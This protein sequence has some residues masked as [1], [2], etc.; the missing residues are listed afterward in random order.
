MLL[1]LK[2]QN[3]ALIDELFVEFHRGFNIITGETG[4]GKSILLGALGLI[5]GKRAETSVLSNSDEKCVVEAEFDIS[6]YNLKPLFLEN[7]IDFD[8][9]AVFRREIL[10]SGKSRA[11]I[12]DTPVNLNTLQDVAL[13]LVDIHSQHQNLLL[14][15]QQYILN[16]VDSY[17][18]N[19]ALLKE[20]Q[21]VYASFRE[22]EKEYRLRLEAYNAIRGELDLFSFQYNELN[23]A[24]LIAGEQEML[25]EELARLENAGDIKLA[26]HEAEGALTDDEH[27]VIGKLKLIS[28]KLDRIKHVFAKA[29]GISERLSGALIELKDIEA[30]IAGSFEKLEF[31]PER[32]QIIK[33]R[34]D[35]INS[36]LQKYRKA[37]IDGLLE[38]QEGLS[39][40]LSLA[41]DGGEEIKQLKGNLDK[42][43]GALSQKSRDLTQKRMLLF[44]E[45]ENSLT[46]MLKEMGMQHALVEFRHT[47]REISA[48][49]A[50]DIALHFT[51]NKN[52]PLQEVSKI[53]SGGELSRLMLAVKALVSGSKKMPT[54][55]LDEIDT[56]VS[57]DIADKVGNIIKQMCKESQ[58]INITHLPQVASKGEAHFLVYKDHDHKATRTLIKKL[59]NAERVHEIAKML[60]GEQLSGAAV[61]NARILL[62]M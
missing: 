54:L 38:M 31:D 34:L 61:E 27:G 46:I 1:S 40:K 4:A 57:G 24:K 8:N 22:Q 14:N 37:N 17:G 32:H 21:Q 42:L 56:G 49:G 30:D 12:N 41:T 59:S 20:F 23:D 10:S 15:Q 43:E 53:A 60:S 45:I 58:I 33:D 18:G 3:Y 29:E 52:H 47:V 5:L 19:D 55:I 26:L 6:K 36:L 35:L 25:E 62:G 44:P 28:A 9:H 50:D 39:R 51:A 13:Q 2:V 7:D 48:L 11:F 16:I